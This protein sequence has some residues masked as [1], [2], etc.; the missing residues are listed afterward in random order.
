[1]RRIV[2]A[3][4]I[5]SPTSEQ[6][7]VLS[8]AL[9]IPLRRRNS[10]YWGGD[11][12]CGEGIGK[13][14]VYF[15]RNNEIPEDE[16]M[17][18]EVPRDRWLLQVKDTERDVEV[19]GAAIESALKTNLRIVRP[20]YREPEPE[21]IIEIHDDRRGSLQVPLYTERSREAPWWGDVLDL[22]RR[23]RPRP[24][25]R[26]RVEVI[27]SGDTRDTLAEA[28]LTAPEDV[29][30]RTLQLKAIKARKLLPDP[31]RAITISYTGQQLQAV[32]G[33]TSMDYWSGC[34]SAERAL[35]VPFC[36]DEHWQYW[37]YPYW[38]SPDDHELIIYAP[39]RTPEPSAGLDERAGLT[40]RW[41]E[42]DH[43]DIPWILDVVRSHRPDEVRERLLG[44]V[45]GCRLLRYCERD[46]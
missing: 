38:R 45:T 4:D 20:R 6:V 36:K 35:E 19:L 24:V 3:T 41:A 43:V 32:Y 21:A 9:G 26:S 31:D 30:R 39:N 23:V 15:F 28:L 1:M 29:E 11:Y 37:G 18:S 25:S 14:S 34:E 22:V 13:E 16:P 33:I 8:L 12:F 10:M 42:P 46:P 40:V 17:F 27:A 7:E 5:L 2:L 44:K